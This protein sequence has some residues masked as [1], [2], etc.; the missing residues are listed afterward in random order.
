MG[1]WF[2]FTELVNC[3]QDESNDASLSEEMLAMLYCMAIMRSAQCSLYVS[4]FMLFFSSINIYFLNFSLR[5]LIVLLFE[6]L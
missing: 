4:F 6:G 5:Y 1:I 2:K 3:R